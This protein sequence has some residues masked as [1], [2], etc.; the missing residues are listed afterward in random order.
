MQPELCESQSSV[1]FHKST[2]HVSSGTRIADSLNFWTKPILCFSSISSGCFHAGGAESIEVFSPLLSTQ[3][4]VVFSAFLYADKHC[5][6]GSGPWTAI[7][8]ATQMKGKKR[9]LVGLS[10]QH[11]AQQ[12]QYYV[13]LPYAGVDIDV[14]AQQRDCHLCQCW[15]PG[16]MTGKA[17]CNN[18]IWNSCLPRNLFLAY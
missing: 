8:L 13:T 11:I 3:H 10:E 1:R 16:Q 15:I 5:R 18:A 4:S 14:W 7:E 17:Q 2:A 6:R 12:I 9:E